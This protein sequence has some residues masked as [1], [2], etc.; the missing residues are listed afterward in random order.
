[1]AKRASPTTGVMV[2]K[3]PSTPSMLVEPSK[4]ATDPITSTVM[5]PVPSARTAGRVVVV[6][7]PLPDE[8][9]RPEVAVVS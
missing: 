2:M 1:M 6:A 4:R 9:G 5:L 8:D 7:T 3:A